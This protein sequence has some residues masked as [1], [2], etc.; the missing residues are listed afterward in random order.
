MRT[1]II[2]LF[3]TSTYAL[4]ASID[5][6]DD[7]KKS[8]CYIQF[9]NHVAKIQK[10]HLDKAQRYLQAKQEPS[11]ISQLFEPPGKLV[12]FEIDVL[13]MLALKENAPNYQWP[14][15]F[16]KFNNQKLLKNRYSLKEIQSALKIGFLKDEFCGF[17]KGFGT[18]K[19]FISKTI[20]DGDLHQI[21]KRVEIYDGQ[22]EILKDN[23]EHNNDNK[24]ENTVNKN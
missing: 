15:K 2:T 13:D 8:Q 6:S 9:K 22:R 20:D 21:D 19:R 16:Q 10:N 12:D 1:L 23:T 4:N 17:L 14:T 11:F 18:V 24:S 5:S 3:F 7:Y